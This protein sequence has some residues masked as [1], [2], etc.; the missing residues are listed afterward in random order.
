MANHIPMVT[1]SVGCE[2]IALSDGVHALIADDPRTF[3]DACLRVL[4]SGDLRQ[5]LA[6]QAAEL[7]ASGYRW[8]SVESKV[9]DLAREVVAR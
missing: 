3:A 4:A 2:G 8:D 9:A 1:T 7:F 6:D 5:R